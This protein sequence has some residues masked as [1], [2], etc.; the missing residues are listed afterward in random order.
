ML[1]NNLDNE[2]YKNNI[3]NEQ[4]GQYQKY[5]DKDFLKNLLNE[6]NRMESRLF[7]VDKLLLNQHEVENI[8]IE[9]TSMKEELQHMKN[10]NE[11]LKLLL[12][13]KLVKNTSNSITNNSDD[14]SSTTINKEKT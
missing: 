3:L 9:N 5:L 4:L 10:E 7:Q 14:C 8:K 1:K 11:F 2:Q 12:K 6:Y 13:N